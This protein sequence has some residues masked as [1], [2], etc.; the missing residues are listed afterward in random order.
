MLSGR[1]VGCQFTVGSIGV[2]DQV[3]VVKRGVTLNLT[4]RLPFVN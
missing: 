1:E 2:W 3:R 4:E